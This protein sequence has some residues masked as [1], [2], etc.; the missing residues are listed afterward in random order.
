MASLA[1]QALDSWV[2]CDDELREE[3]P[4]YT[5]LT[6]ERLARR[7]LAPAET[8][9]IT[10]AD[11]FA[12]I[13]TWHRYPDVLDLAHFVVISRPGMT[14]AAAV[15]R[16]PRVSGRVQP[17]SSASAAPGPAV[18]AVEAATPDVSSTDIR[19]RLRAGLSISGLVPPA[20]ESHILRHCL[21]VDHQTV[22]ICNED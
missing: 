22:H 3:G 7:G 17:V 16:V 19:R 15:E 2:A 20:V 6:L 10:G 13:E 4:S 21:Y 14:A 18:F 9:F 5:A 8:F 11:A 1:V 12:E